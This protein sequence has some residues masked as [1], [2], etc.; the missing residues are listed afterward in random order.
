M[1]TKLFNTIGK[2]CEK[3]PK[4]TDVDDIVYLLSLSLFQEIL[5]NEFSAQAI[6]CYAICLSV[7]YNKELFYNCFI[8]SIKLI[9]SDDKSDEIDKV[10]S[11]ILSDTSKHTVIEEHRD[12]VSSLWKDYK[13]GEML[14][15]M[16]LFINTFLNSNEHSIGLDIE[17]DNT[18]MESNAIVPAITKIEQ[19]SDAPSQSSDVQSSDEP[20]PIILPKDVGYDQAIVTAP[21]MTMP[22][23]MLNEPT[24]M[25]ASIDTPMTASMANEPTPMTVSMDTPMTA[26]MT[27]PMDTPMTASMTVSMIN[28]PTPMTASMDTPMTASMTAPMIASMDTPMTAP[29]IASMD[30]PMDTPMTASM[31]VSMINEPTP[32][33]ASMDTPM[34]ASMTA[35]MIASMDTP[36]IAPM[37]ASTPM[38][39]P[40]MAS[41]PMTAS[42]N[43]IEI[44]K[45]NTVL[46]KEVAD[47][48]QEIAELKYSQS[49]NESIDEPND[50]KN[51][52]N[53]YSQYIIK[54][55]DSSDASSAPDTT[56]IKTEDSSDATI[57]SLGSSVG[58]DDKSSKSSVEALGSIDETNDGDEEVNKI[59]PPNNLFVAGAKKQSKKGGRT[60][61]MAYRR[62]IYKSK[63]HINFNKFK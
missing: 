5:S 10:L 16:T 41:T 43:P 37:M 42:M 61:A 12:M 15:K 25:T 47:L 44:I 27:T 20:E 57:E 33:T 9:S 63:R 39:T 7:N 8:A 11:D 48:I 60:K 29:M 52:S 50:T 13:N 46:K 35:P 53:K 28:E 34:T 2:F 14:H 1:D 24:P 49:T 26:S 59:E 40:M 6:E 19:S 30:T 21:G 22:S 23:S 32:M 51:V 56:S 18:S 3:F 17:H 55:E 58:S 4:K 45:E 62:A 54:P 36:M 31:T 38:D